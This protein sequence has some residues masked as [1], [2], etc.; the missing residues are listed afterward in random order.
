MQACSCSAQQC[1]NRAMS[2]GRRKQLGVEV[3]PRRTYGLDPFTR[4]RILKAMPGLDLV[5]AANQQHFIEYQLLP[6]L[7]QLNPRNL[8]SFPHGNMLFVL[9]AILARA[10]KRNGSIINLCSLSPSLSLSVPLP[11][12]SLPLRHFL[13]LSLLLYSPLLVPKTRRRVTRSH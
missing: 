7:N 6:Q 10:K 5:T 13:S 4:N 11:H 1:Q 9:R 12:C 2:L 8:A 3:V